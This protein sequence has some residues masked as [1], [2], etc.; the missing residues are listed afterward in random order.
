MMVIC[1][2]RYLLQ[3]GELLRRHFLLVLKEDR[4]GIRP[5]QKIVVKGLFALFADQ[6]KGL[7]LGLEIGLVNG[8]F[9]ELGLSRL[10]ESVDHKY[11]SLSLV[12][13]VLFCHIYAL[14]SFSSSSSF[15]SEPITQTL[16]V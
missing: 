2:F 14:N 4:D 3:C 1:W 9:E 8:K 16:P 12:L 6:E 13:I 5:V 11:R 10:Q 15:R 7:S